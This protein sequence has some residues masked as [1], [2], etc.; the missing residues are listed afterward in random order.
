[1]KLARRTR[2]GLIILLTAVVLK[3]I[4][5]IPGMAH[6]LSLGNELES[7][8]MNLFINAALIGALVAL[9]YRLLVGTFYID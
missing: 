7:D 2:H 3:I 4:P 9:I 5:S 1:M 8:S 6:L